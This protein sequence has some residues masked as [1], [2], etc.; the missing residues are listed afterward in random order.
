ME[1]PDTGAGVNPVFT[2]F[3][4]SIF[5]LTNQYHDGECCHTGSDHDANSRP[6]ERS[7]LTTNQKEELIQERKDWLQSL[8][9]SPG[10]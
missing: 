5:A 6:A 7:E 4:Q 8:N 10:S 1:T 9:P 2:A 3:N